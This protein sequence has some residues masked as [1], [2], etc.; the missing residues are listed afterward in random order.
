M[1]F[2]TG[3][4]KWILYISSPFLFSL[5]VFYIF[6]RFI[7]KIKP[8]KGESKRV[9]YGN[10]IFRLFILLP[11]QFVYDRLTMNPDMFKES[12]LHIFA[13][14][15]GSGKTITVAYMLMRLKKMYPKLKIKTNF[16]Y[17]NED[18]TIKHWKDVIASENGIYG[19]VDVID[20][21]QNWFNSLQSKDFPIEMITEIT[22]QRKQ[23]KCIFGTSQVFSRV[24]KPIREQTMMLYE[25]LTLF[26]CL[27]IVRVYKPYV[28]ADS[29][30]T[31]KKKL[32]KV[33]FF[34]HNEELRESY[35]TYKKIEQMAIE[36]FSPN[37]RLYQT[38]PSVII[39]QQKKGI[40]KR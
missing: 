25:P 11:K 32:R 21:I 1:Q 35:D 22:Q 10:F 20:E 18:G 34:V 37:E 8:I 23:K 5:T 3:V 14:E 39:N 30:Q 2:I 13:G 26:G 38:D 28:K 12:G 16:S 27:T 31:D 7:K 40:F 24:A 36:G 19:E 17:K 29:G 33:F 9:G 15:Q 6:Y 4:L